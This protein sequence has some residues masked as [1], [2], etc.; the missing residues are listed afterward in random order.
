MYKRQLRGSLKAYPTAEFLSQYPRNLTRNL[1]SVKGILGVDYKHRHIAQ[2]EIAPKV[3]AM[4]EETIKKQ[5]Y[6]DCLVQT[7]V[8]VQQLADSSINI[9]TIAKFSGGAASEYTEIGWLLQQVALEACNQNGW[10]IPF[11]QRTLHMVNA[12][13]NGVTKDSVIA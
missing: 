9:I 4:L 5:F 3:K 1:F 12:P 7:I 6:G 8:E 10:E 2:S 11:P 13:R